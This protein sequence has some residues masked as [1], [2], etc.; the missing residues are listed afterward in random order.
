[1][2]SF[3]RLSLPCLCVSEC[4]D[5]RLRSFYLLVWSHAWNSVLYLQFVWLCQCFW[6]QVNHFWM[7][8]GFWVDDQLTPWSTHPMGGELI[9]LHPPALAPLPIMINSPL[10]PNVLGSTHP[11]ILGTLGQGVSWSTATYWRGELIM[12][13]SPLRGWLEHG[14]SWSVI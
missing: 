13:N 2:V 14:V 11:S 12:I 5:L 9:L 6:W 10:Q 4:R 8:N 7:S 1:M 3:P